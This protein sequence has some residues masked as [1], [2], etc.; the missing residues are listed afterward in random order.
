MRDIEIV[1]D[2]IRENCII[3]SDG[4]RYN[5]VILKS[6]VKYYRI[7]AIVFSAIN[8]FASVGLQPYVQQGYISLITCAVSLTTGIIVSIELF[9]D[10]QN[11]ME[12]ELTSSKD[13]YILSIDIFK[14]LSLSR[15]NRGVNLGEYLDEK[16]QV[17]CELFEKSTILKK[18]IMDKLLPINMPLCVNVDNIPPASEDEV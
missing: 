7:P 12:L 3:M 17:Y 14:L 15:E 8:V 5:Y 1:L 4:H 6:T 11:I 9:N 16:Y 18:K 13:F 2:K 10:V